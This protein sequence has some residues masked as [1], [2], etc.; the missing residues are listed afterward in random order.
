M[1]SNFK[2]LLYYRE[3]LLNLA[4]RDIKVRYKQSIL[5]ITWTILQPLSMMIVFTIIFTHFVR[6]QTG[7]IPYPLFSYSALLPW[8]FFSTSLM[9]AIPSLVGNMP[10]VTKVYFPREIFPVASIIARFIDFL[11]ASIIFI[12]LMFFY[13]VPVSFYLFLLLIVIT[14]QIVLTL[15]IALFASAV[16]V[17]YRDVAQVVP[18]IVQI[19]MYL[20]PII[21]PVTLVPARYRTLYMLNPMAGIIDSYRKIIL[22][23]QLPQFLYLGTAAIISIVIFILAY[24]YFKKAEMKFAD[25]I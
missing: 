11:V 8:S 2:Q 23:Q 17:F 18:L 16:N 13:R 24:L 20:T 21:Y 5:G 25:I 6:V 4:L 9:S 12:G 10:L 22:Q 15:G 7:G 3:L 19:W 1:L 14:I